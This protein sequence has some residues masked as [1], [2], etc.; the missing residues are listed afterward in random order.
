MEACDPVFRPRSKLRRILLALT[1]GALTGF[2]LVHTTP[3]GTAISS[4]PLA[5]VPTA[6]VPLLMTLHIAS[7]RRLARARRTAASAA[8]SS[9]AGTAPRAVLAGG[10]Q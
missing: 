5:L 9:V 8:G 3:S 2:Q 1:L 6:S 4:L 7:V 10:G